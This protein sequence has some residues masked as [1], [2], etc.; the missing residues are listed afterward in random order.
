VNHLL[1]TKNLERDL[2]DLILTKSEGIPFFTEE[3]VNSFR[4]L[5]IIE[6]TNGSYKLAKNLGS[7]S[8][9][10]TIQDMIMAR[11]D[12][13]PGDAR[14]ILRIGS[15][16]ER[17]F[18]HRLIEKVAELPEPELL[19][20][21]S[22]LKDAELLYERGLPPQ[23]TYIFK[24]SL[25]REVVYGSI[26]EQKK[27]KLHER[28]GIALEEL[29]KERMDE[30]CETLASHFLAAGIDRKGA[31]YSKLASL[32]SEKSGALKNCIEHAKRRVDALERLS[33][34]ENLEDEVIGARVAMALYLFQMGYFKQAKETVDIIQDRVVKK[35]F[36]SNLAMIY[37]FMGTYNYM[38]EENDS[39]SMRYLEEAVRISEKVADFVSFGFASYMLGLVLSFNCEFARATSH[40][41]RLL[42]MSM[43]IQSAWRASAMKS[44]LS[45][46]AYNY[47]GQV[48]LGFRTSQ[49]A[50]RMAEESGDILSMAMAYTSHGTSCY[51]RGFLKEA[52]GY[53][54][55]GILYS[56]K[57][58]LMT[59]SA[60]AHQWLGHTYFDLGD[61]SLA[62][63]HYQET[64]RLRE[65][66]GLFPSSANL[67]RIALARASIFNNEKDIDLDT[68]YDRV[69][70]NRLKLYE[71]WVA[72]FMSEI[73]MH[74]GESYY[75]RA[76][77]WIERATEADHRNHMTWDLGRD[78]ALL[79]EL[80]FSDGKQAEAGQ[81]LNKAIK[82]L[83]ECGA[84][85]WAE[86]MKLRFSAFDE[87]AS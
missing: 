69:K 8:I 67:N 7:I 32:K 59:H 27:R 31:E 20:H 78:Y 55:K 25:T 77:E 86:M 70:K 9:P 34:Y 38:V 10:S 42:D 29:H 2:E 80:L 73:L 48:A 15:A 17:E 22:I 66:S 30:H 26:L 52:E 21:L 57:I 40:F 56:E 76:V 54:L 5:K 19:S 41:Q 51:Y 60:L 1:N 82:T 36:T 50:L 75:S 23:S 44:N 47:N 68:L 24:H 33:R 64:I 46:Y 61:Y 13:L 53:L 81:P 3:I 71:G 65:Q 12:H 74:M 84:D 45:V 39:E 79:G 63:D 4:D 62:K 72:R 85:G 11:I 18:D 49:E 28:I 6:R 43:A 37:V 58:D 35:G 83:E 87:A 16:I 14:E